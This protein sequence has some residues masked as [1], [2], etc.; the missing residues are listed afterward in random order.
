M[1]VCNVVLHVYK[2]YVSIMGK[3]SHR[4]FFQII[5]PLRMF[6]F[7]EKIDALSCLKDYAIQSF[8]ET[9]NSQKTYHPIILPSFFNATTRCLSLI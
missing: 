2:C 3:A 6:T 7:Q 8:L 5:V 1:I 9:Y 4:H